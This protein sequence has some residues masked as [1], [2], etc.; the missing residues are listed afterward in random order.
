MMS[1]RVRRSGGLVS[2]RGVGVWWALAM[3]VGCVL[4]GAPGGARSASAA[5]H[6]AAPA[7]AERTLSSPSISTHTTTGGVNTT[8]M[9]IAMGTEPS[10]FLVQKSMTNPGAFEKGGPVPADGVVLHGGCC[11]HYEVLSPSRGSVQDASLTYDA[12]LG[13]GGYLGEV[14][15][16]VHVTDAWRNNVTFTCEVRR[17]L[18]MHPRRFGL[19]C[20]FE[21]TGN[22]FHVGDGTEGLQDE[23]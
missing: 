20:W 13:G 3:T 5:S 22:M 15:M 10:T 21:H 17:S 14:T 11:I 1:S 4:I 18:E 8:A 23:Q 2:E 19:G 6:P 9:W 16:K 7:S 12:F